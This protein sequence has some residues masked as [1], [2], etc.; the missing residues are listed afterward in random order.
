MHY[1]LVF[2]AQAV[3]TQDPNPVE[4]GGR[5]WEYRHRATG[6]LAWAPSPIGMFHAESGDQACKA[7]ARKIGSMGVFFAVS[8]TPWGVSM[9][10]S[11]AEEVG[12]DFEAPAALTG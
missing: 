8:G 12:L 1:W 10:D 9:A 11:G 7:A 6:E 3:T 5:V 4:R 2:A